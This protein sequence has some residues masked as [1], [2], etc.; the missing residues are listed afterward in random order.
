MTE[1]MLDNQDVI[2]LLVTIVNNETNKDV[3]VKSEKKINAGN[4]S[5]SP[6]VQ[7]HGQH[8]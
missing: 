4:S 8:L 5:R 3:I 1:A 7:A 6:A 2:H